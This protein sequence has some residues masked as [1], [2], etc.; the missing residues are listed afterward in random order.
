MKETGILSKTQLRKKR[1]QRSDTSS[2]ELERQL[3]SSE[4]IRHA[5]KAILIAEIEAHTETKRQLAEARK[6]ALFFTSTEENGSNPFD[7]L[8]CQPDQ[9]HFQEC[10]CCDNELSPKSEPARHLPQTPQTI[11]TLSITRSIA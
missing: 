3:A 10:T 6:P 1:M 9:V 5:E 11:Q 4:E 8:V 2:A 7:L